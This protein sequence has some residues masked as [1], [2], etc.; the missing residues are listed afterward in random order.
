MG[1]RQCPVRL[2][3][4]FNAGWWWCWWWSNNFLKIVRCPMSNDVSKKLA[5]QIKTT[6]AHSWTVVQIA[7]G[8]HNDDRFPFFL[9][10]KSL[11]ATNHEIVC[12]MLSNHRWATKIAI[13]DFKRGYLSQRSRQCTAL[14]HTSWIYNGVFFTSICPYGFSLSHKQYQRCLIQSD[15]LNGCLPPYTFTN[16]K[17]EQRGKRW[18]IVTRH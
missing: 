18:F 10:D 3:L 8:V 4:L 6:W 17:R 2:A 5:P 9:A 1:K 11:I 12:N 14:H 15:L 13:A 7:V 16:T